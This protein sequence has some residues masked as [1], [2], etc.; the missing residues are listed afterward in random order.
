MRKKGILLLA[1]GLVIA[2]LS[3]RVGEPEDIQLTF[4]DHLTAGLIEQ[5]V[6]VET[7]SEK[8]MRVKTKEELEAL[9]KE[10]GDLKRRKI[11]IEDN[12]IKAME[13][14]E[15]CK[16]DSDASNT[17]FEEEIL[18][19]K[20]EISE[21]EKMLNESKEEVGLLDDE[22]SKL[23]KEVD[24]D[25]LKIY[26]RLSSN[27]KPPIIAETS[28]EVCGHCNMKIP[29]QVYIKVLQGKEIVLAPCCKK[30]IIPKIA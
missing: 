8:V 7:G 28:G 5:D 15:T 12:Q 9:E 22:R 4:V 20:S 25:F 16:K 10:T 26:E 11:E 6:Y 27:N 14:M 1:L 24:K 13:E 3:A 18:P 30:I 19:M 29:P 21:L 2:E 17:S 23:I